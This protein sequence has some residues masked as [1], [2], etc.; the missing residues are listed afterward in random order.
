MSS[1]ITFLNVAPLHGGEQFANTD[2]NLTNIICA[3]AC[4]DALLRRGKK[5]PD[6][7]Y[8][9]LRQNKALYDIYMLGHYNTSICNKNICCIIEWLMKNNYNITQP[10]EKAMLITQE[11]PQNLTFTFV[12]AGTHGSTPIPTFTYDTLSEIS[13]KTMVTPDILVALMLA[14]SQLGSFR[15]CTR[16]K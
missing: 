13:L 4:A 6:F 12:E 16:C 2:Q 5:N 3:L 14:G 1:A 10:N 7:T 15:C 11:F 8:E 9:K